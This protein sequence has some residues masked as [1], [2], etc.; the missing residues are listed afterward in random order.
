MK[1]LATPALF[2]TINPADIADPFLAAIGGIP[3]DE[4]TSMTSFQ[5]SVLVVKNPAPAAV[6]FDEVIQAFI[7]IILK[8]NP[9][10]VSEEDNGIFGRCNGYY[11]IVEAQ[12]RG[13]LHC[14]MLI[15]LKGNPTPQ[16]LRDRMKED[17]L[18]RDKMFAWLESIIS[19]QLPS[20]QE[21]VVET[22]GELKADAYKEGKADPRL[23][24]EPLIATMTEEDFEA[25]FKQTVG[26]LV[27]ES[28]WHDHR[29]TCWKHLK[30]GEP[31]NDSTCRMR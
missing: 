27:I 9:N 22:S 4:W 10:S 24:K 17:P 1:K 29:E 19:C 25:A 8:Y 23:T 13:I 7:R 11:A 12:R 15:W 5:R 21:V 18:F 16:E 26:D 3:P 30:N 6:F 2:T 31:R 28:N 14:H 20:T